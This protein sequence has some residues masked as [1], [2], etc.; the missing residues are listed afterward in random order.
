M[1]K[2]LLITVTFFVFVSCQQNVSKYG[3]GGR[4]AVQFIKEQVPGLQDDIESIEVIEEDSLLCDI[5]LTFA[6]VQ[7]ARAESEYYEGK[8]SRQG[9]DNIIDSVSNAIKDVQYSWQYG[10]V[11]NDSLRKI[12][13]Y[14]SQWRK[15]YKVCVTMKSGVKKYP[16]VLMD[17]DG[18][19]PRCVEKDFEKNIQ[20]YVDDMMS[21]VNRLIYG[22]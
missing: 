11:V 5:G 7:L 19:T 10:I 2:V 1:K 21:I 8:I 20:K 3:Q 17:N 15:V 6:S 16:R 9:L 13:K 18:I 12:P 14:E 22:F 4:N